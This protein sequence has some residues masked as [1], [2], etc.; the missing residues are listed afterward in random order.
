MCWRRMVTIGGRGMG[1]NAVLDS[2]EER[3]VGRR[4]VGR[5][6]SS[7]ELLKHRAREGSI[8]FEDK[9]VREEKDVW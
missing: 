3:V 7:A 2:E 5:Q 8:A 4:W 9:C 6:R 1:I